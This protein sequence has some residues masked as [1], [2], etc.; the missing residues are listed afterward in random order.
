MLSG[1][2]MGQQRVV[3]APLHAFLR[4]GMVQGASAIADVPDA[5]PAGPE[6]RAG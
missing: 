6:V 1:T 3:S 4:A 5:L 2:V